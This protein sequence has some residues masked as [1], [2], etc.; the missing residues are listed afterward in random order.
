MLKLQQHISLKKFWIIGYIVHQAISHTLDRASAGHLGEP[1]MM[2]RLTGSHLSDTECQCFSLFFFFYRKNEGIGKKEISYVH[3]AETFPH[4]IGF[5]SFHLDSEACSRKWS[6]S[7]WKGKKGFCFNTLVLS[8]S[9][10]FFFFSFSCPPLLPISTFLSLLSPHHPLLF[11][12]SFF[13]FLW[14]L[15][16]YFIEAWEI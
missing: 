6:L 8:P 7:K 4:W 15:L 5:S 3:W 11:L 12:P 13:M 14:T 16:L 10:P 9:I 2:W 1:E